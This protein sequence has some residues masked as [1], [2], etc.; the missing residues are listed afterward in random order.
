[1]WSHKRV[2]WHARGHGVLQ[3]HLGAVLKFR[4][5]PPP[6]SLPVCH[7]STFDRGHAPWTQLIQQYI[8][9]LII[10]ICI[11]LVCRK[12]RLPDCRAA[13]CFGSVAGDGWTWKLCVALRSSLSLNHYESLENIDRVRSCQ[14][15]SANQTY[16]N[17]RIQRIQ[18]TWTG[19]DKSV[20]RLKDCHSA[21]AACLDLQ[22]FGLNWICMTGCTGIWQMSFAFVYHDLICAWNEGGQDPAAWR[23]A[24]AELETIFQRHRHCESLRG[25][26]V[27]SSE[28]H[29]CFRHSLDRPAKHKIAWDA[30]STNSH[31]VRYVR[32]LSEPIRSISSLFP[33]CKVLPHTGA[34][35][36]GGL[37]L[38]STE[39]EQRELVPSP[40][41]ADRNFNEAAP[42]MPA[43]PAMPAHACYS[44]VSSIY[45]N[46]FNAMWNAMQCNLEMLKIFEGYCSTL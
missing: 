12:V 37:W 1:M 43:M 34:G 17:Q 32:Y 30:F 14:I 44:H 27:R 11:W 2:S 46:M 28:R 13:Q 7:V 45:F 18:R 10:Y 4:N 23:H 26:S 16:R 25:W 3:G 5:L 21:N 8:T 29:L 9:E 19:R 24:T 39:R 36:Y 40:W 33:F 42:A 20:C 22:L 6:W 35:G 41:G 15:V 31:S 38:P